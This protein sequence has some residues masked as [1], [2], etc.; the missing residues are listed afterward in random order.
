VWNLRDFAVAPTFSGGRINRYA[1]GI[2]LVKGIDQKGLF[3]YDDA[4]KPAVGV[5]ARAFGALGNY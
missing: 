4:A 1:P 2:S 5:V 3:G